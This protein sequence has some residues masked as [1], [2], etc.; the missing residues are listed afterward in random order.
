[1]IN[2]FITKKVIPQNENLKYLIAIPCVNR[3]ERNAVNVIDRTFESFEKSGLFESNIQV[4]IC[5]FESGSKDKT[6]LDCINK[7]KQ[8]KNIQIIDTNLKLNAVSN[9]LR[10][11]YFISKLKKDLYDYVLWMDDDIYVCKNFILN[12]DIWIKRYANFSIFSSL[13]VPYASTPVNKYLALSNISHFYGTCCTVF[14]P[15]LSKYVLNNWYNNHFEKFQYNPDTRFRDSIKLHFPTAKRICVSYP[16][17]VEHMN[18]GSSIRMKK[19]ENNGHKS[20]LFI[21]EDVDP[22]LTKYI[23]NIDIDLNVNNTLND[24]NV[25]NSLN[26]SHVNDSVNDHNVTEHVNES[27]TESVNESV[28]EP[29]NEHVNESTIESVTEHVNEPTT[30]PVTESVNEPVNEPTTESVN[31]PVNEYVT[32]P[33]TEPVNEH[34]I[35]VLNETKTKR[36]YK[37][38]K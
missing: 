20:K 7:Y 33:T 2:S 6:Y 23:L 16:S 27:T 34:V 24:R 21:G 5:L 32:E 26:D 12:A 15:S 10:M 35:E 8:Y 28:I 18:I 9:T 3:L 29:V 13:Y 30:E 14:K 31:E 1:M 19:V 25:N 11:M 4:D 36:K 17:F 38:K 22:N 37:S